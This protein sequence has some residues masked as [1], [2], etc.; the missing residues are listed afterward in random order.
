VVWVVLAVVLGVAGVGVEDNFFELGGHSLLAMRL[1]ERLRGRGVRVSVRTVVEAPTPAALLRRLDLGSVSDAL[2]VVLPVRSGGS[3]EPLWCV[4][5]AGGLSWCYMPLAR[6]VP[7]GRPV[8]GLQARGF[9]GVSELAASVAE[10]A[11]DYLARIRE[12]QAEG[13]YFLLGWSFGGVVAQEIAVQL[14]EA[15]EQVAALIIM[16]VYPPRAEPEPAPASVTGAPAQA[17][18]ALAREAAPQDAAPQ[19]AGAATAEM[20]PELARIMAEIRQGRGD[21]FAE[22]SEEELAMFAR[23]FQNNERLMHEHEIRAFD[24]DLLLVVAAEGKPDE[25]ASRWQPYTGGEVTEFRLA[26]SHGEMAR[27]DMLA[28]TWDY[29]PR[30]LRRRE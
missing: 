30:W 18:T 26:C 16:D 9:D 1:V 11:A 29:V 10:M 22:I 24:G 13:P 19:V 25:V 20:N 4:H 21:M 8:L 14:R 12:V 17:G 3:A 28:Q 7:A 23:I 5:P 6:F 15:G 2:R 27:P